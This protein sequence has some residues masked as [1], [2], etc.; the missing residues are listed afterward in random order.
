MEAGVLH[1][2][3]AWFL[4]YF[5]SGSLPNSMSLDIAVAPDLTSYSYLAYT[6]KSSLFFKFI[7]VLDVLDFFDLFSSS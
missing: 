2:P 5:G 1:L 3:A 4:S 6:S 7:D